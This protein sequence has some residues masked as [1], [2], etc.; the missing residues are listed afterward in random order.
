MYD[1]S[2]IRKSLSIMKDY[3]GWAI[4]NNLSN[5]NQ[6]NAA[7]I[8]DVYDVSI[9]KN[10]HLACV[11]DAYD[12]KEKVFSVYDLE[13]NNMFPIMSFF[14]WMGVP[15]KDALIIKD[16]DVDVL[17]GVF[18]YNGNTIKIQ[19][20]FLETFRYYEA[21]DMAINYKSNDTQMVTYKNNTDYFIKSSSM[22]EDKKQKNEPL[23][24]KYGLEQFIKFRTNYFNFVGRQITLNSSSLFLS[25]KLYRMYQIEKGG[26]VLTDDM[27][28]ENMKKPSP[29]IIEDKRK[30]YEAYKNVFWG[31]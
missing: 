19:D 4:S 21:N 22:R 26:S 27:F 2:G 12:L 7:D 16:E 5:G 13:N 15:I 18:N 24:Y 29:W 9:D 14:I 25:G 20:E 28:V 17:N 31:N 3:I 1:Y 10:L 23:K 6:I 11:K 30:Q 8:V